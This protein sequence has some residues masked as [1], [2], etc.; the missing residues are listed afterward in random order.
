V[1]GLQLVPVVLSLILLGAHFLR[2]G[3]LVM[4][5][6]VLLFVPLLGVRRLWVARLVQVALVLGAAEWVR[7]LVQMAAR[8][9]EAGEP[10]LRLIAI[11]GSVALVTALSA[12]ALQTGPLRRW[13][14][15]SD[16]GD[17]GP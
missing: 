10:M 5:T 7:A 13:Y 15:Q 14:D 6:L 8:R 3:N 16:G 17:R 9:S 4:V 2:A 12:I 1:I 11:L